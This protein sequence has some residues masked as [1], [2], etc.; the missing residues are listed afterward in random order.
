[1]KGVIPDRLL[2][3]ELWGC[4]DGQLGWRREDEG[5]ERYGRLGKVH[6]P[7]RRDAG[8]QVEPY[9]RILSQRGL[10]RPHF[11]RVFWLLHGR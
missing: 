5:K 4:Q 1:M 8:T 6:I 7:H 2:A 11:P 3:M 10:V 9:C